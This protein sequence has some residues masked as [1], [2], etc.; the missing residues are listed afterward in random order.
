MLH[1]FRRA[2]S[3]RSDGQFD[4]SDAFRQLDGA[5]ALV[6]L[7][8]WASM[9]PVSGNL[10]FYLPDDQREFPYALP[11]LAHLSCWGDPNF[12]EYFCRRLL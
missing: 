8:A 4:F 3:E 10:K 11:V 2:P 12:Y 1:S 6:W 9:D 7:N 5:G